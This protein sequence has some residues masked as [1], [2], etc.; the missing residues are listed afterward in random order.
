MNQPNEEPKSVEERLADLEQLFGSIIKNEEAL[1][2]LSERHRFNLQQISGGVNSL[3]LD[4][5]DVRERFDNIERTMA[6]KGDIAEIKANQ[7]EQK[8]MLKLILDE[9]RKSRE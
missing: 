7:S 2:K 3:Q 9:L 5:G 8:D 4:M 6:T 1:I